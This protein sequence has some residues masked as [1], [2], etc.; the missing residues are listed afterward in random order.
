MEIGLM[1]SVVVFQKNTPVALNADTAGKKDAYTQ[2][3]LTRGYL[4][5]PSGRR[6]LSEGAIKMD[7]STKLF[8]RYQLALINELVLGPIKAIRISISGRRFTIESWVKVKERNSYI[9]F[10]LNEQR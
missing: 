10:V 2:F 1:R 7:N 5:E 4:E 8:V 6:V 9:K 3:A